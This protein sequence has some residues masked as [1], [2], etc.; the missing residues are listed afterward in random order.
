[1]NLRPMNREVLIECAQQKFCTNCKY[2]IGC[3]MR[4]YFYID[5]YQFEIKLQMVEIKIIKEFPDL[6]QE[7][8]W[9]S[10]QSFR[11]KRLRELKD[12]GPVFS[13]V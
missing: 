11:N 9:G 3:A 13:Y 1:M 10:T 8:I 12:K 7:V 5:D 6:D 4:K 2:R